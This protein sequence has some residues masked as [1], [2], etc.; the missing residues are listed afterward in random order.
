[1]WL[2]RTIAVLAVGSVL[3]TGCRTD[4]EQMPL[5]LHEYDFGMIALVEPGEPFEVGLQANGAFPDD[6]WVV[7]E[8]DPDIVR[9]DDVEVAAEGPGG[10]EVE[11]PEGTFL[12]STI[13]RFTAV[14]LGESALVLEVRHDGLVV[15]RYAVTVSV[16][17]DA[18]DIAG[19]GYRYVAA[20]RC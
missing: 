13:H 15:D 6:A 11:D 16:V 5:E 8:F 19:D 1:M 18:C 2:L 17:A 20:N 14:A 3:V 4:F 9:V 10:P 12:P 7:A